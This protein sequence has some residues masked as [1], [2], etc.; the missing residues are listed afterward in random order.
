MR[1]NAVILPV[2][3][4]GLGAG[5]AAPLAHAAAGDLIG[6]ALLVENR[7]TADLARETRTLATG[8]SVRQDELIAVDQ[9]ARS[10]LVLSD[11][12]KLALGPGAK[13]K[14]DRFVFDPEKKGGSIAV[15]LAKGTLR[16]VTGV[17][18]KPAYVIRVPNASIT[19]RGTIFDLYVTEAGETWALLHEGAIQVCNDRGQC[20]VHEEACK[21]VR[22][23]EGG[24]VARPARFA[25]VPGAS[26][27]LF[28]EAFPFVAAPPANAAGPT[29]SREAILEVKGAVAPPRA[30]PPKP[31]PNF[32]QPLPR[33]SEK[34]KVIK[35]SFVPGKQA[36]DDAPPPRKK[37]KPIYVKPKPGKPVIVE[38]PQVKPRP[39]KDPYVVVKPPYG[40]KPRPPTDSYEPPYAGKPRPKPRPIDPSRWKNRYEDIKNRAAEKK[41]KWE[42]PSSNDDNYEDERPRRRESKA[43][44]G[45]AIVGAAIVGGVLAY[46][47]KNRTKGGYEDY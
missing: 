41:K 14:L 44:I 31:R 6:S 39:P 8:D 29:C 16:W 13:L 36:V 17:A 32:E 20:R 10:E 35:P 1:W 5:A 46:G 33:K 47:L 25:D 9:D 28:A 42:R 4:L 24:E 37:P 3:V 34:A 11:D 27:E 21:L 7:V 22:V 18:R 2:S 43:N 26:D 15:S 40:E 19:V 23:S 30:S 12:T 38:L 45:K